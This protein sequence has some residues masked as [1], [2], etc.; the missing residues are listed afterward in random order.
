MGKA[1]RDRCSARFTSAP[2]PASIQ[3]LGTADERCPSCPDEG[4]RAYV[5]LRNICDCKTKLLSLPAALLASARPRRACLPKKGQRSPS[6]VV[7]KSAAT[8][9]QSRSL[10]TAG[11]PS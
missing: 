11:T 6:P 1:W 7:T 9:E 4:V 3:K 2:S 8:P 10:N 5:L